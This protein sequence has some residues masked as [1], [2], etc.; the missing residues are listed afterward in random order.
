IRINRSQLNKVVQESWMKLH[1]VELSELSVCEFPTMKWWHLSPLQTGDEAFE[2]T[3]E[4]PE[5]SY[6]GYISV[7]VRQI[8]ATYVDLYI[9]RSSDTEYYKPIIVEIENRSRS[10]E[11]WIPSQTHTSEIKKGN[12]AE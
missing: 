7:H 9:V 3:L 6:S 12:F 4:H 5:R 1:R 11:T 8:D 10:V 2:L